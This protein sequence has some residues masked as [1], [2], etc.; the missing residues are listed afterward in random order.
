MNQG[1]IEIA[2]LRSWGSVAHHPRWAAMGQTTSVLTWTG[3]AS[4]GV[5]LPHI[6]GGNESLCLYGGDHGVLSRPDSFG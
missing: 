2:V 1:S 3:G 6:R 4:G 5:N